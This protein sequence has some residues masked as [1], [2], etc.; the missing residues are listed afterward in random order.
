MSNQTLSE[1]R[2]G[3]SNKRH[4]LVWIKYDQTSRLHLMCMY[5]YIHNVW[6]AAHFENWVLDDIFVLLIQ[7]PTHRSTGRHGTSNNRLAGHWQKILHIS[8]QRNYQLNVVNHRYGMHSIVVIQ[9]KFMTKYCF[10]STCLNCRG[11]IASSCNFFILQWMS[12]HRWSV[13]IFRYVSRIHKPLG[14]L[15]VVVP[16]GCQLSVFEGAP[17]IK[18]N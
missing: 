11:T 15:I 4:G 10:A 3:M 14:C 6:P 13:L 1:N 12:L 18:T 7:T 9:L 8:D 5:I 17:Q 2:K 16:F